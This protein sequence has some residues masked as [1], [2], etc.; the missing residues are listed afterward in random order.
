MNTAQGMATPDCCCIQPCYTDILEAAFYKRGW[1]VQFWGGHIDH[2]EVHYHMLH[3]QAT[4]RTWT[5]L[6]GTRTVTTSRAGRATTRC[7]CGT[8]ETGVCSGS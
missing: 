8:S 1:E 7:G 6:P 5:V 3:C 4:T 2:A